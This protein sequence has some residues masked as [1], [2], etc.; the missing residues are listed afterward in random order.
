MFA[1]DFSA[2]VF[3]T[4]IVPS[5][6]ELINCAPIL[7]PMGKEFDARADRNLGIG[8]DSTPINRP[9]ACKSVVLILFHIDANRTVAVS[10][11]QIKMSSP[12]III[13]APSQNGNESV[14]ENSALEASE[15]RTFLFSQVED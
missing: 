12:K 9:A 14:D 7:R 4:K 5:F 1:L 10:R 15:K 8:C 13:G 11:H 3:Y 6:K 2:S